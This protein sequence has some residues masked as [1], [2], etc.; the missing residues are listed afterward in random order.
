MSSFD[1]FIFCELKIMSFSRRTCCLPVLKTEDQLDFEHVF[2]LELEMANVRLL[3]GH[4]E[5]T[6]ILW[7]LVF[8]LCTS[9]SLRTYASIPQKKCKRIGYHQYQQWIER[10]FCHLLADHKWKERQVVPFS[11]S[12]SSVMMRNSKR[13]FILIQ[14]KTPSV[15]EVNIISIRSQFLCCV[16]KRFQQATLQKLLSLVSRRSQRKI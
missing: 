2:T 3:F 10:K 4:Q 16:Q 8:V 12:E 5:S 9:S 1:L 13:L 6:L 14:I 11:S 15:I 7:L